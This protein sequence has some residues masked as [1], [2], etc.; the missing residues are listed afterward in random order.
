MDEGSS[1]EMEEIGYISADYLKPYKGWAESSDIQEY[2]GFV[3]REAAETREQVSDTTV[4]YMALEDYSTRDP[5]QLCL[6]KEDIVV[7]IE[8]SEDGKI[9]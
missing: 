7:I 8:M 2:L 3:G 5:R 9:H 6:R 4:K 1:G